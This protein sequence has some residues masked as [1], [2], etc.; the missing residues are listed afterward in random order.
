M[1][2]MLSFILIGKKVVELGNVAAKNFIL[3][4]HIIALLFEFSYQFPRG[5]LIAS[6]RVFEKL[7]FRCNHKHIVEFSAYPPPPAICLL[8]YRRSCSD[9]S[10]MACLDIT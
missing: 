7:E 2:D 9:I 5:G 3:S 1:M 6:E 10:E 8:A 4:Q